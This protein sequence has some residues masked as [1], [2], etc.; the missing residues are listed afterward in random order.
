MLQK[1]DTFWMPRENVEWIIEE[2]QAHRAQVA[3]LSQMQHQALQREDKQE[4]ELQRLNALLAEHQAILKS[5][6]ER[7]HQEISQAPRRTDQ[8][9]HET[10]NYLAG[11]VNVN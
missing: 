2:E 1:W 9:R 11:N 4:K 5:S 10:V 6:P 3:A 8:L 7:P